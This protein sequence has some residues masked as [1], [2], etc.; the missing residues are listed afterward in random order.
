MKPEQLKDQ[1][2]APP[3]PTRADRVWAQ[4]HSRLVPAP[5]SKWAVAGAVAVPLAAALLALV[6]WPRPPTWEGTQLETGTSEQMVRLADGTSVTVAPKSAVSVCDGTASCVRVEHGQ[7]EFQVTPRTRGA[8]RVQAAGVEVRVVG[9]RFTVHRGGEHGDSNVEVAVS[10]GRVEVLVGQVVVQTLNAGERWSTSLS[11]A[12]APTV[13]SEVPIEP[14]PVKPE[15]TPEPTVD[16]PVKAPTANDL[17]A[18]AMSA[19][20]S[21][22]V[23]GE[24][25]AY[26]SLVKAFPKDRRTA[27]AAFELAR[28]MMDVQDDAAHA[29]P[30]LEFAL[31][32]GPHA[33]FVED[34]LMRLAQAQHR[35]GHDEACRGAVARSLADFPRGVH[36]K[37]LRGLCLEP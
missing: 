36:A 10:H 21:N 29:I 15:P 27:V 4:V 7:A 11:R 8:F 31:A 23:P 16:P 9:T 34:A 32:R 20:A 1:Y 5:R 37:T 18:Q 3:D 2:G 26:R 35:L 28:L 25:A 13:P 17:W 24:T 19:R 14:P 12:A 33:A 30:M 6:W 22:D